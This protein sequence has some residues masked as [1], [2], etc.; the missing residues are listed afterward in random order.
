M[1]AAGSDS[2]A[3][4]LSAGSSSSAAAAAA[5][6]PASSSSGPSAL[7]F[8]LPASSYAAPASPTNGRQRHLAKIV[9]HPQAPPDP[10][11]DPVEYVVGYRFSLLKTL[12]WYLLALLTAGANLL[13]GHW[14]KAFVLRQT[15]S[16]CPLSEAQYLLV[17]R[18]SGGL[19]VERLRSFLV[20][21][22]QMQELS[23]ADAQASCP[24]VSRDYGGRRLADDADVRLLHGSRTPSTSGSDSTGHELV[25]MFIH[26]NLRYVWSD[27]VLAFLRVYGDDVGNTLAQIHSR[28]SSG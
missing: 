8:A 26:R 20:D 14:K 23:A 22:G 12:L 11:V 28:A 16:S 21:H 27:E 9:P 5:S 4:S 19:G 24:R 25:T 17:V 13:L 15:C 10:N 7:P 2:S 18:K 6:A 1:A 3:A